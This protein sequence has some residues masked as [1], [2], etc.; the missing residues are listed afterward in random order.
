MITE[1]TNRDHGSFTRPAYGKG[2]APTSAGFVK[3]N[4]MA[5]T[6][7]VPLPFRAPAANASGLR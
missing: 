5:R 6:L 2:P 7:G 4:A 1:G 3:R